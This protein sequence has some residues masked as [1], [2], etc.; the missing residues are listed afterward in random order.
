MQR[1]LQK[2]NTDRQSALAN[3]K[4]LQAELANAQQVIEQLKKELATAT[5]EVAQLKRH[6]QEGV[7]NA[8]AC[9]INLPQ[10]S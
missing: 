3:V 5:D 10:N 2:A 1:Q 7:L 8:F 4:T 9:L 6:A